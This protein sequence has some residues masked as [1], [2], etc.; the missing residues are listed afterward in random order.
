MSKPLQ[1]VIAH[2]IRLHLMARG[3]VSIP[4]MDCEIT[5]YNPHLRGYQSVGI[6]IKKENLNAGRNERAKK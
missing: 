5:I 4:W 2:G 1:E 3:K 6:L